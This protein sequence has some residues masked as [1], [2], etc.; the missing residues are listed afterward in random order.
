MSRWKIDWPITSTFVLSS[1][2]RM[3]EKAAAVV[4]LWSRSSRTAPQNVCAHTLI[5]LQIRL[6]LTLLVRVANCHHNTGGD[7][8]S[9]SSFSLGNTQRCWWSLLTTDCRKK[10]L[11]S[12]ARHHTLHSGLCRSVTD[13]SSCLHIIWMVEWLS[14]L[15]SSKMSC[16]A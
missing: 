13:F 10:T 15:S 12:N 5:T 11:G 6:T 14:Q 8:I 1:L 3:L 4:V 7:D 2:W 16:R 9:L